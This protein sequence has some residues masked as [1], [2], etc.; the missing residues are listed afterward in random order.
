MAVTPSE[1]FDLALSRHRQPWNWT[2]HLAG[3]CG[4][5]LT[6][7]LHSP[8]LLAASLIMF[9]AGFF[10]WPE[11]PGLD[12]RWFRFTRQ[13][14]EWEKNWIAYPWSVHKWAWFLLTLFT[15]FV[16]VWALWTRELATLG[17]L[18]G[19]AYLAKVVRENKAN[20]IDP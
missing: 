8:L 19:F 6:L 5:G 4:L 18:A 9:G 11:P 12:S 7:L 1:L 3:L 10:Q 14:V 17:I 15:V 16:T 13:A 20:D 2:L